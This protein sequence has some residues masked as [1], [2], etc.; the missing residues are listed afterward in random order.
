M[1]KKPTREETV[2]YV[3]RKTGKKIHP[4]SVYHYEKSAIAK[5]RK[6]LVAAIHERKTA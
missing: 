4:S 6:A 3:F 1:S 5:I 2:E